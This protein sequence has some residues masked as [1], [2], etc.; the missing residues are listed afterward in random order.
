M[1]SWK[2]RKTLSWE[3]FWLMEDEGLAKIID[4]IFDEYKGKKVKI[5]I[6]ILEERESDEK[7]QNFGR[8]D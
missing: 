3:L 6:E 4:Q 8:C 2:R 5:T 7:R 1:D